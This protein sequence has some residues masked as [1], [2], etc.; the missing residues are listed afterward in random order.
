MRTVGGLLSHTRLS[1]FTR[2][3][4]NT[5]AQEQTR[6]THAHTHTCTHTHTHMHTHTYAHTH[7]RT[8]THMHTHTCTHMHTHAHT[9]LSVHVCACV[10]ARYAKR[11]GGQGMLRAKDGQACHQ[12]SLVAGDLEVGGAIVS[13]LFGPVL[14]WGHA[15]RTQ[16]HV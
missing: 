14:R 5:H 4:D 10:C 15:S 1:G 3:R 13:D 12:I 8:H 6:H 2:V 7:I 16:Q 9:L 11:Q